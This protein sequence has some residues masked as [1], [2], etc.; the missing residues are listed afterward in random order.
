MSDQRN[1]TIPST[2]CKGRN[3]A[4]CP[5][6]GTK[7]SAHTADELL[8]LDQI[9]EALIDMPGRMFTSPMRE[10]IREILDRP[11]SW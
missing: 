9:I 7:L 11:P 6:C 3:T 2:C 5:D 8:A 4:Y 10:K 1:V